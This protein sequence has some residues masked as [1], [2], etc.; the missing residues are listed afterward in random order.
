MAGPILRGDFPLFMT[1]QGMRLLQR[2]TWSEG[3]KAVEMMRQLYFKVDSTDDPYYQSY[4]TVG[5][6]NAF[7]KPEGTLPRMDRPAMGRPFT[8]V[9]PTIALGTVISREA[10]DDDK[11]N[12]LVPL[13]VKGLRRSIEETME[14]DAANMFNNGFATQGWEIDGVPLFSA[15]HPLSRAGVDGVTVGTNRHSTDAALSISSLDAA[16]TALRTTKDDSGRWLSFITPKYLDVHPAL[17]PYAKTLM[18][19]GKVLGS[20]N[21][22][23]NIYANDL[24]I[25]ANPRFRYTNFWMLSADDHGCIWKNRESPHMETEVDKMARF[26]AFATFARYG[27]GAED[28]RGIFGSRGPV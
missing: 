8:L 5:M 14:E 2:K 13:V 1:P 10:Q 26:S 3:A 11:H 19:T 16:Y 12:K 9:F 25:R 23:V 18:R 15:S 21:N 20:N 22:D 4:G 27:Y 17:V 7:R 24:I 6:G 28:W